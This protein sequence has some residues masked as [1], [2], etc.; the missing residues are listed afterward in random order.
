MKIKKR[1]IMILA[2]VIIAA[3]AFAAVPALAQPPPFSATITLTGDTEIMLG[4]STTLTAEWATNRDVTR[5]EW[6]INAAGQGEQEISGASLGSQTFIFNPT[7]VGTYTISFRIWHHNPQ[8]SDRVASNSITVTVT[9]AAEVEYEYETA[10]AYCP[11]TAQSF[12]DNDFSRWGWTNGPLAEGSYTFDLYAGAAQ[13]DLTKGIIVGTV[14]I[15]YTAGS[16]TATFHVDS[17][18]IL[19]ETHVYA[20]STMFPIKNGAPTVA[21]G[22][23]YIESGLEGNIYVIVHAIVGIPK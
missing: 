6:A 4:E 15:A 10:F 2:T 1:S 21:P 23:Y 7:E 3:L 12:I 8:Q 11:S 14:D 16:L 22:Q 13:C 18:Y 5:Y 20:G 17:P 19:D 9:D